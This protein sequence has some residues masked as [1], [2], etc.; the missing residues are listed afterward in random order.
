MNVV[1]FVGIG[2]SP[3]AIVL[4]ALLAV[5]G[6]VITLWNVVTVSL[7]QQVVPPAMLGRVNSVYKML[8]WG[9]IPLGALAGGL[10]AHAF[11]LRAPYPVAGALRGI[12]LL[13]AM[14]V[15]IR[16]MRDQ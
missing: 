16:A 7:R 13:V 5:N 12:A 8:G 14:P 4:G 10:V 6:F 3:N 1:V 2:L 15:L 11:G 9:L